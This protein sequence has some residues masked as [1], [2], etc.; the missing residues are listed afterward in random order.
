LRNQR[1][2]K[3][4]EPGVERASLQPAQLNLNKFLARSAIKQIISQL[5]TVMEHYETLAEMFET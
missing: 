1:I 2:R 5:G 3:K 4:N